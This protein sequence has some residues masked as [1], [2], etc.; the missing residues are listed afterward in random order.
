M[1]RIFHWTAP[2]RRQRQRPAKPPQEPTSRVNVKKKRRRRWSRRRNRRCTSARIL[3]LDLLGRRRAR[4]LRISWFSSMQTRKDEDFFVKRKI[5]FSHS[6][7][8]DCKRYDNLVV[9]DE[10][11][12]VFASGNYLNFFDVN[13]RTFTFRKSAFGWGIGH[14]QVYFLQFNCFLDL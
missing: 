1:L 12:V 9:A 13:T 14:I 2:Q 10:N 4:C 11:T 8:Y 7:G 6:F 5:I 3:F